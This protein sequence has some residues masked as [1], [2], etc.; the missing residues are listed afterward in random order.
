VMPARLRSA[1]GW[2]DAC[3]LNVSSGGLLVHS[4]RT[5]PQGSEVELWRG[6]HVI[7][8]RVVW[9][10]GARAGLCSVERLPVADI[11]SLNRSAALRLT[12]GGDARRDDCRRGPRTDDEPRAQGQM[13][14]FAG[15]VAV[16]VALS[17]L[18]YGMVEQALGRPL[19]LVSA[20]LG[21]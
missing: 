4:A 15:V 1:S 18:A 2:T 16:A 13:V 21:G 14:E 6:E 5:G 9:R 19:A 10:D 8:A 12:A 11:L 3:I 17:V 20:A 7:V